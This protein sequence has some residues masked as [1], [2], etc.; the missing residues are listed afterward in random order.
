[1]NENHS[2]LNG[3]VGQLP[4][5]EGAGIDVAHEILEGGNVIDDVNWKRIVHYD[6]LAKELVDLHAELR[7]ALTEGGG[8]SSAAQG[9][10]HLVE[11]LDNGVYVQ[12]NK[13]GLD[14]DAAKV[15]PATIIREESRSI[16]HYA[17]D[18]LRSEFA[19]CVTGHPGIGKTRG[20]MMYAIQ[21][22]LHRKAAVLYVGNKSDK[23]LLFLPGDGGTYRVWRTRAD[24]F[25]E[26]R[27][28][29]DMRVVA[30]IDPPEE[31]SYSSM[32][33]CRVL[34]FV[35]NNAENHFRNWKKDGV[36]FV[37]SMPSS[38]EVV[39][40]T[41]VLWNGK[42]TPHPWQRGELDTE[43]RKVAEVRKRIE[44]VGSIPRLVFDSV[45]FRDAVKECLN[46]AAEAAEELTDAAL[47]KALRGKYS[48]FI[49]KHSASESSRILFLNPET[50]HHE[51]WRDRQ[52]SQIV[53]QL[54]PIAEFVLRDRLQKS[55][56]SLRTD[57]FEEFAFDWL[58]QTEGRQPE[59][60]YKR[61]GVQGAAYQR[62]ACLKSD[63]RR[64][65]RPVVKNFPFIDF[66]T[67][68]VT[69]FNA[70]SSIE[71]TIYIDGDGARTFLSELERQMNE[72]IPS[73][74]VVLTVLTN[75]D[76]EV[77][78]RKTEEPLKFFGDP[79][80]LE[81]ICLNELSCVKELLSRTYRTEQ[82]LEEIEE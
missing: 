7:D 2:K 60:Q 66:A 68:N 76:I 74:K 32:G 29:L 78:L 6:S 8:N 31:G 80:L 44:L 13:Y 11:H 34:K 56:V 41:K 21:C 4:P 81:V 59:I 75:R 1:M 42:T 55:I 50:H 48:S 77:K 82:L 54:T 49:E 69:W 72:K 26:T 52:M 25:R 10:N 67:S 64:V 22:L 15:L 5:F 45:S 28:A 63:E 33:E 3:I 58:C 38:E 12:Y 39:A 23:M 17:L 51:T 27:L 79:V 61:N 46:G 62:I 37:T 20:C 14:R 24:K 53:F 35:S 71:N 70:K 40:M 43:E 18:A 30:V 19:V 16:V 57:N 47:Y 73:E 9:K 36:L 65:Y